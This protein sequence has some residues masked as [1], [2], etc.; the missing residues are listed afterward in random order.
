MR[1]LLFILSFFAALNINA[2][3]K[4][5]TVDTVFINFHKNISA[6]ERM[7]KND[8]LLQAY[9]KFDIAFDS[10]KGEINPSHYFKASLCA[11][12]IKE[13]YKS[14]HFLENAIKAGYDI[15][16][17]KIGD[18]V[19]YNQNTK[20]EYLDN[21][22]NWIAE[23]RANRNTN[24]EGEMYSYNENNKKYSSAIYKA[25][26]DFCTKCM[27]NPKCNKALPEYKSKYKMVI[28]KRKS[29]SLVAITLIKNIRQ[30]GFPNM[31]LMNKNA[32]E[33]ARTILM[34]YDSDSKNQILNDVFV[35][36][37]KAG[38]ISPEY[39]ATV[40]DRRAVL[41]GLSMVFYE[42]NLGY[43]KTLGKELV[44]VNDNRKSI[45]LY[46]IVIVNTAKAKVK[47]KDPKAPKGKVEK[48]IYIGLYDY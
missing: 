39:Y 18:V 37:L 19:F 2:Q 11:L 32:C 9:A 24:W 3:I 4:Y 28:E 40:V 36:A 20:K 34:N 1:L 45:G 25:A 46:P 17:S 23:G 42:P 14:L 43:D 47:P 22:N 13:E 7:Y 8:S 29:D 12:A 26:F 33:I 6:A 48:P 5:S 41:S 35:K 31:K 10:Y 21:I 16:S 27:S 44:T 30:Y 15:D 38:Q